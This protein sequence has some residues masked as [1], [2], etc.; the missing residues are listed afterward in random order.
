MRP[1]IIALKPE[2]EHVYMY[3]SASA[4]AAV[5]RGCSLKRILDTADWASEKNFRMFYYRQSVPKE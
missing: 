1:G 2:A 3:R 4:L 5:N